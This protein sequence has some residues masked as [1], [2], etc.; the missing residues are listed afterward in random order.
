MVLQ[1]SSGTAVVAGGKDVSAPATVRINLIKAK[2]LY[3]HTSRSRCTD[4]TKTYRYSMQKIAFVTVLGTRIEQ[5]CIRRT[6]AL[7]AR[8]NA[9]VASRAEAHQSGH[10]PWRETSRDV[11]EQRYFL[12]S[13]LARVN[14]VRQILHG[15]AVVI[16]SMGA[17]DVLNSSQSQEKQPQNHS[18]FRVAR[19]Q[20]RSSKTYKRSV[21]F[22]ERA[23]RT[24][25]GYSQQLRNW[26][27]NFTATHWHAS[28]T[29]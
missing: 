8:G 15:G 14:C 24:R 20:R 29:L 16:A 18:G 1:T 11:L 3:E 7:T 23:S 22:Q 25:Q 21:K 6:F 19:K 12:S 5:Q 13:F 10:L 9:G 28:S 26:S 27:V 17:G 4:R 2:Q